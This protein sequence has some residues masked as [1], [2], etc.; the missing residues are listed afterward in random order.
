M[1]GPRYPTDH[2]KA[3]A[4]FVTLLDTLKQFTGA[5]G[6]PAKYNGTILRGALLAMYTQAVAFAQRPELVEPFLDQ[7]EAFMIQVQMNANHSASEMREKQNAMVAGK[8]AGIDAM[9]MS[10]V[11]GKLDA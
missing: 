9:D 8:W 5:K 10:V 1:S 3:D 4:M 6:V 7:I 11:D 2:E